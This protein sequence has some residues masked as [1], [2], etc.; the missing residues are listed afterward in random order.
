[1]RGKDTSRAFCVTNGLQIAPLLAQPALARR[2]GTAMARRARC[3]GDTRFLLTAKMDW[4]EGARKGFADKTEFL[5]GIPPPSLSLA[6]SLPAACQLCLET[7][8]QTQLD[9]RPQI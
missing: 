3:H 9:L 1:M 8:K 5:L 6:V 4:R 2:R 7:V